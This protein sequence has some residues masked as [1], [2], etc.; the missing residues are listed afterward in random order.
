MRVYQILNPQ[1]NGSSSVQ[2][3]MHIAKDCFIYINT[4]GTHII[5]LLI[6]T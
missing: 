6:G 2:L 3:W 4:N 1:T 5:I